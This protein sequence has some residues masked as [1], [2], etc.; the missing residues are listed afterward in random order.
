[1]AT[2]RK[3]ARRNAMRTHFEETLTQVKNCLEDPE[4]TETRLICLKDSLIDQSEKLNVVDEEIVN[5]LDPGDVEA[6]VSDSMKF[7]EP[8]YKVLANINLRLNAVKIS[9]SVII[10][11]V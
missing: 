4:S 11:S 8:T 7:S 6:D 1:M 2:V 10:S 3:K 5:L 9:D